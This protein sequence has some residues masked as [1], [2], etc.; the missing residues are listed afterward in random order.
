[1]PPLRWTLHGFDI[2]L[3]GAGGELPMIFD[4]TKRRQSLYDVQMYRAELTCWAQHNSVRE[5]IKVMPCK[6][7]KVNLTN[8]H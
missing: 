2:R 8:K 5:Q 1:M 3:G 4:D 6:L 7:Q